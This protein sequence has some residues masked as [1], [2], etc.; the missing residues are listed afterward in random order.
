[1]KMLPYLLCN[2]LF[3]AALSAQNTSYTAPTVDQIQ[4]N[5]AIEAVRLMVEGNQL[6]QQVG[7]IQAAKDCKCAI[8]TVESYQGYYEML[9]EIQVDWSPCHDR[10][11]QQKDTELNPSK[12]EKEGGA[13]EKD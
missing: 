12:L 11:T 5:I 8:L 1:M 13:D 10:A 4:A 7:E 2:V 6:A 9:H 3:V